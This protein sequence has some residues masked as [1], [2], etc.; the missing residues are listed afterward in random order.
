MIDE[1]KGKPSMSR[2]YRLAHC[3]GSW[4]LELGLRGDN[5]GTDLDSPSVWAAQGTRIHAALEGTLDP[6]ELTTVEYPTYSRCLSEFE[7]VLE[8]VFGEE[9]KSLEIIREERMW[10]GDNLDISG[11]PDV[12]IIHE[13]R[14]LIADYKTGRGD[15]EPASE[16]Y[17]LRGLAV[18]AWKHY[19][20]IEEVI[21]CIIQPLAEGDKK[22]TMARYDE[23]H[24]KGAELQLIQ[25]L[26]DI[27]DPESPRKPG[28][29]Q[30]QYC[31]AQA[32]CPE[33]LEEINTMSELE[34]PGEQQLADVMPDLL[35]RC[36]TAE[37][38]IKG[39]REKATD[40]LTND[41]AAVDG[42]HLKPGFTRQSIIDLSTLFQRLKDNYGID[43]GE[44][45][46]SCNITK[47]KVKELIKDSTKFKGSELDNAVADSLDGLT[48]STQNKASL[49]KDK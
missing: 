28:F 39:I 40:M 19:P 33:A 45:A 41:P 14:C 48:K 16:N 2:L 36:K 22:V 34:I 37:Q 44:F 13:G 17:Q 9:T 10:Y 27:Q 38:I 7:T 5:G 29:K 46:G 47:T 20:G 18:S 6:E 26:K 21:V 15:V 35:T 24:L 49:T 1:R 32:N 31:P 23:D 11:Q 3:P 30:C 25:I 42:W 43:A 4:N 8:M 12:V